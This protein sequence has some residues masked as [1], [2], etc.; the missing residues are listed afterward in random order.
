MKRQIEVD[1]TQF[2]ASALDS[3]VLDQTI[4]RWF[5]EAQMQPAPRCCDQEY[6]EFFHAATGNPPLLYDM[7]A[8][9]DPADFGTVVAAMTA[10]FAPGEPATRPGP[11]PRLQWRLGKLSASIASQDRDT[12]LVAIEDL[13][14]EL[15]RV[16][17]G[18]EPPH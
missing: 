17:L 2:S 7:L 12:G 15:E 1:G 3:G 11:G 5:G 9:D 16:A 13:D 18:I 6:I 4:C 8:T 10:A 14:E